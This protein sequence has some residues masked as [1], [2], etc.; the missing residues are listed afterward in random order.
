MGAGMELAHP[1]NISG[2]TERINN[3]RYGI[4]HMGI[5]VSSFPSFLP[6]IYTYTHRIIPILQDR[7]NS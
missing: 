4:K 6:S 7:H 3:L 5:A 1:Y 2:W